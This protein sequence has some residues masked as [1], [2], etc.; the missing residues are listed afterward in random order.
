MCPQSDIEELEILAYPFVQAVLSQ[1][2][3]PIVCQAALKQAM[4]S[5]DQ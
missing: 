4:A 2:P 1:E 5:Y 3:Q